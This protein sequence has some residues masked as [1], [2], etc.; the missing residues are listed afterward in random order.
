MSCDCS[1]CKRNRDICRAV[2]D[3]DIATLEEI[4]GEM[5]NDLVHCQ[6]ELGRSNAIIEGWWPN[7]DLILNNKREDYERSRQTDE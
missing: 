3:Q 6:D 5:Q 4:I 1:S 2:K 7:A